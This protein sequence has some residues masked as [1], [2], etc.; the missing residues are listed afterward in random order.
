[1]AFKRLW[2]QAD[3]LAALAAGGSVVVPGER[4]ARAVALAHGEARHGAGARV[5]ERPEVLSYGALLQRLYGRA[6]DAAL[7]SSTPPPR[8]ITDAA[9]E[10]QWEKIIRASPQGTGLLQP[11][12]AAREAARAWT[13]AVAY[14]LSFEAIATGDEDAQAFVAW[15]ERFKALSREQGWLEDARLTDWLATRLRER[16]IPAPVRMLFAGFDELTP[17]QQELVASLRQAG[18]AV[19]VLMMQEAPI[20]AVRHV[21][22]DAEGEMQAAAA[23]ARA[24]LEEDPAAAIGIVARDLEGCRAALA[25]ALDDALCPAARAGQA[26]VRAY[27][28]SLGLPLD[29]YPVVHAA[30]ALLDLLRRRTPFLTVSLLLRSPFLAG[31]E[32]EQANR[33]RLEL[34]LR[35][36]VSEDISLKALS[37]FAASLGGVPLLHGALQALAEKSSALPTR[38]LPSVWGSD[39]ADAL[40]RAGWPGARPLDSDEYQTVTSLQELMGSLVQLDTAL[41]PVSLSEMLTRLKRLAG[42]QIFQPAG[43]DAPVQ[44]LGLLETSGLAFDHLW[45]MGLTDEAWPASP[46]PAPFLPPRLQREQGLPHASATVELKF[47]RQLTVRLL[48]SAGDVVVSTARQQADEELRPS[49]LI[50]ELPLAEALPQAPVQ[51]YRAELQARHDEATE[52][53]IDTQGPALRSGDQTR[54]GTELL[55][56]QAAC[57]FQA[58]GRY[59][60]GAK[61]LEEPALGPDALERGSLVHAMLHALWKE[62]RDH[63]SLVALDTVA[64]RALTKRCAATAVAARAR[65]LPEIYTPRVTEI[66]QDRLAARLEAWLALEAAR[67]PFK[68]L[69][70][71]AEHRLGIGPLSLR[72]RVDRIDELQNGGRVILDYKTG[73][74]DV[75]SWLEARPDE[76]QLPLYAVGNPAQLEAVSFACLKPGE[77]RFA[78]LGAHGEVAAGIVDYATRKGRP[79]AAADWPA[80]LG[81]WRANLTVLAEEYARG[82]ARVD[83]KHPDTCK[84]CH[85]STLCRIHEL[86]GAEEPL[87]ADDDV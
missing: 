85:L 45:I 35:E 10:S 50:A 67:A 79:E 58:Y 25:R 6:A 48:A 41:G 53:Y 28:L 46:R 9:V 82:E 19:D 60:L 1:M 47:A 2:H 86:R 80:L 40:T 62:L 84:H 81:Y 31:G 36:R 59:R 5:W 43:R 18:S 33:A 14:R 83:P 21:A 15:A 29:S 71:E 37:N 56:S 16:A 39:F 24:L 87:E 74:V 68:V 51:G 22:D 38:Q 66:E 27:D 57:P 52:S 61:R 72:T 4:L 11:A 32:V 8:R 20:Q 73:R 17:Q 26:S 55:A 78:G 23:W 13:L 44:V 12:G 64:R 7:S 65:E 77:L 54:G 34:R 42:E 63:A 70:S 3:V 30:F 49:P 76:P 75:K 69:E